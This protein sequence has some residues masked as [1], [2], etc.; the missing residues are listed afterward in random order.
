MDKNY[1]IILLWNFPSVVFL[2][3]MNVARNDSTKVQVLLRWK[4]LL[5]AFVQS[6]VDE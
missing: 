4:L 2:M 1:K 5:D 3:K 6:I